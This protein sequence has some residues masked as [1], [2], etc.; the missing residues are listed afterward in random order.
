MF[1]GSFIKFLRGLFCRK[2]KKEAPFIVPPEV[3]KAAKDAGITMA[4]IESTLKILG[5]NVEDFR[6]ALAKMTEPPTL[7]IKYQPDYLWSIT[8]DTP[9]TVRPDG[10]TVIFNEHHKENY[11]S[12]ELAAKELSNWFGKHVSRRTI[13]RALK[14]KNGKLTVGDRT[15]I[16]KYMED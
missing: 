2:P 15:V 7:K 9:N 10:L 4:E 13:Y 11:A 8:Y 3:L 12:Q 6:S 5:G 1:F 16:V 14:E